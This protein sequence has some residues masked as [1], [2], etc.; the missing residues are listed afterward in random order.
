MTKYGI[1]RIKWRGTQFVRSWVKV[2]KRIALY[3][4]IERAD[5]MAQ[6]MHKFARE[7]NI[8]DT[9][10]RAREYQEELHNG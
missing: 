10:Y 3:D 7:N 8:I 2:N 6:A 5:T 4:S 9:D 1:L